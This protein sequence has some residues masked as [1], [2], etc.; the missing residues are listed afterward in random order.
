MPALDPATGYPA[1]F[2][3]GWWRCPGCGVRFHDREER[4]SRYTAWDLPPECG[5]C[6]RAMERVIQPERGS[7]PSL[8]DSAEATR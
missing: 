6:G 8:S 4:G 7:F 1:G 3:P 5:D 2:V